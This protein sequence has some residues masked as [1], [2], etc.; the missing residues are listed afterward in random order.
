MQILTNFRAVL[1]L[2]SAII[3]LIL[4][5]FFDPIIA[6]HFEH[7]GISKDIIGKENSIIK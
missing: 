4:T 6:P 1:S 3:L 5:L 7:I 2:T